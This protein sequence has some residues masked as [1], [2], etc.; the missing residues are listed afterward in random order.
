MPLAR[1]SRS[2]GLPP[3][4]LV[5]SI[6][7]CLFVSI[8]L[9]AW[10]SAAPTRSSAQNVPPSL[11]PPPRANAPMLASATQTP[12]PRSA[13][14]VR[15]PAVP[16]QLQVDEHTV[17]LYHFDAPDGN[18]AI[19]ATGRYT[20][21][22]YGNAAITTTGLYAGV[23]TLD[24]QGSYVRIGN[25]G[26]MSQG[27]VEAYVDFSDVCFPG[28]MESG[29]ISV[30]P[31]YGS[32]NSVM[33][34][35]AHTV[36]DILAN[37]QLSE[38]DSGVN[39]CRYLTGS[40]QR[41]NF[42]HWGLEPKW[43][44]ET[45]RFHHVAATW[46][47]RGMEIWLDGV[48][49]GLGTY[50]NPTPI[51]YLYHCNPQLYVSSPLYPV[52]CTNPVPAPQMTPSYPPGDY[53]GALPG[54]ATFLIGCNS[55]GGCFKGRIDEVRISDV[56][57]TF[58][59]TVVPTITPI[60]T[61]TPVPLVGE[62]SPDAN[63]LALYH[64]NSF[65]P[66]MY[67]SCMADAVSGQPYPAI[68][69]LTPYGHFNSALA[70]SSNGLYI[71]DMN[72]TNYT[73][74]TAEA[75]VRFS[76]TTAAQ[77]VF[78]GGALWLGSYAGGPLFFSV[79]DGTDHRLVITDLKPRDLAGCWHHIAGTWG[80]RGLEVWLDGNLYR[81]NTA[82]VGGMYHGTNWYIGHDLAGNSLDGALDEVR[83]S[84]IQRTFSPRA[85]AA[86]RSSSGPRSGYGSGWDVFLPF[87]SA[88]SSC[89]FG[90]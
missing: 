18:L 4:Q 86:Q 88:G 57:R 90:N 71:Q 7:T 66:C 53:S 83:V 47:P 29:I 34:M 50:T 3:H 6:W 19:D 13:K 37:G 61:Q 22:L 65:A 8:V 42:E 16:G 87:V 11:P 54:Y 32:G 35:G 31:E 9:I 58:Q 25:L 28:I 82:F 41:E 27:T 63:T 85:L 80:P 56:Q 51:P 10:A 68:G 20:G 43:P 77:P 70:T 38:A 5:I 33:Q 67:A 59:Y 81:T 21:T 44:Y 75:W 12:P 89:P 72:L 39:P 78:D 2:K 79:Y 14:S 26:Q 15:A 45:W 52:A 76:Q 36:L 74:G 62:Y 84:S 17:A 1:R 23:L 64:L 46:G 55:S 60:P 73:R 40:D 24:G 48:L 49:Y 30:G 69:S